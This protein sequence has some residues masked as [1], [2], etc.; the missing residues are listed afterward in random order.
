MRT[1]AI[2]SIAVLA[3]LVTASLSQWASPPLAAE[4]EAPNRGIAGIVK[5]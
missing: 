4:R 5:D 3:I 2:R 1:S